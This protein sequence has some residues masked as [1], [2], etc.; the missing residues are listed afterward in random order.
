VRIHGQEIAV[1]ARIR[2]V[3]FY[4]AHADREQLIEWLRER[5]P[6]SK[7]IFLCH[8]EQSVIESLRSRLIKVQM[9]PNLLFVPQLDEVFELGGE[10]A[11]RHALDKPRLDPASLSETAVSDWHNDYAALLLELANDL[12]S[13]PDSE[14]RRRMLAD[15]RRTLKN[16]GQAA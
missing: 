1:K 11:P 6:I 12:R 7:G 9:D 8:G 2:S 15:L 4:S 10:G 14:A 13:L 5:A 3:D 16:R